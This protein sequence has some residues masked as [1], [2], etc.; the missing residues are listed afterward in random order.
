M[1]GGEIFWGDETGISNQCQH[2]RGYA[3]KGKTP[4]VMTQSK[5]LRTNL[6]SAV[7]NQG[8]VRFM[9][10]REAMT[11]QVL[12]R[13]MK[14]LIDDTNHKVYLILDNLRVHHAKLVKTGLEKNKAAIEVYYLPAYSPDMNPDESLN[15]DLKQGIR[16][17][18]PARTQNQLEKKVLGYMRKIQALP[19]RVMNYF[20]HPAIQYAAS[21]I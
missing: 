8:K 15:C 11:A 14:R 17:S 20:S 13:F 18:S 21:G 16:A 2:E 4:L 19:W 12:I 6:I 5:R 3:P 7:N 10:Y 9:M 1:L